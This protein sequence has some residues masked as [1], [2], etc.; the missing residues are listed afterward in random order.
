[1]TTRREFLAGTAAGVGAA[2]LTLTNPAAVG[3]QPHAKLDPGPIGQ[4]AGVKATTAPDGVVRIAWART[5]V[6]VTV[7]GMPLKP[8]AGLG[9]W[10]AFTP[11]PHGAMAM[12]DTVVIHVKGPHAEEALTKLVAMV[13]ERFG[14]E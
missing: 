3:Q 7:D 9:S 1:M 10:A 13:E 4:A 2:A 6:P 14:E 11:T 5:D 8:F 12:G